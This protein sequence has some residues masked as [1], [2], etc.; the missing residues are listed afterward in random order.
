MA[1]YRCW[2]LWEAGPGQVGNI[3]PAELPIDQRLQHALIAWSDRFYSSLNWDD[4]GGPGNFTDADW[5]AF[6]AEGV[7][8]AERLSGALGTGWSV[9]YKA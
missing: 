4:P 6:E 7:R 9:T 2:P 1:D 3:D 8:L 5:A